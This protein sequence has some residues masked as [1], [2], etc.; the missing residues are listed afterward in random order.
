MPGRI[1]REPAWETGEA[2]VIGTI[3][4]LVQERLAGWKRNIH[5]E[6]LPHLATGEAFVYTGSNQRYPGSDR[7]LA[8]LEGSRRHSWTQNGTG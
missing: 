1:V 3:Q 8:V 4:V 6:L 7:P 5:G 2:L